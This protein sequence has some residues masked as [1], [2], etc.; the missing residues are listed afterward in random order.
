MS[1]QQEHAREQLALDLAIKL[2]A[3][4]ATEQEMQQAA[5]LLSYAIGERLRLERRVL[6]L[7]SGKTQETN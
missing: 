3:G 4:T 7:E 6:E 5:D 1:V 2:H